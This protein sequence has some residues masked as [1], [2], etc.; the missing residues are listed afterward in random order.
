MARLTFARYEPAEH[1][2]LLEKQR[3]EALAEKARR[4]PLDQHASILGAVLAWRITQ[5]YGVPGYIYDA[6]T[7][8]EMLPVCKI[9]G[10]PWVE[11]RGQ[12]H[13]LNM[14]A[15]AIRLCAEKGLDYHRNLSVW[16]YWKI[17]K[18]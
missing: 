9:T 1:L 11:R 12:G 8:D 15:A 3:K 17:Y 2:R 5:E 13:N 7:V 10:L 4:D 16:C 6:V 18:T 14:R